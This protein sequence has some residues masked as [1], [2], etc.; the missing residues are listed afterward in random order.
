MV[1]SDASPLVNLARIQQCE[2]LRRSRVRP[3]TKDPP[4]TDSPGLQKMAARRSTLA[5]RLK[6]I[7]SEPDAVGRVR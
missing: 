1:I 7:L 3:E 2:V 6:F 4:I 5:E